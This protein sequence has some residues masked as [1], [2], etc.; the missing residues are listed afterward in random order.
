MIVRGLTLS[1]SSCR[2]TTSKYLQRTSVYLEHDIK[3]CSTVSGQWQAS[4]SGGGSLFI[5]WGVCVPHAGDEL[6]FHLYVWDYLEQQVWFQV[7]FGRVYY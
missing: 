4:Q 5:E 6:R 3:M 1:K 2:D 7:V